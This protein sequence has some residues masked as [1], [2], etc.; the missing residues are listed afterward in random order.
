MDMEKFYKK[1]KI[2]MNGLIMWIVPWLFLFIL[3]PKDPSFYL[4]DVE[5]SLIA[6]K[7]NLVLMGISLVVI[8]LVS[9]LL[10]HLK[11]TKS[12]SYKPLF[13]ISTII[14]TAII[15]ILLYWINFFRGLVDF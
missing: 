6:L 13:W 7:V 15:L 14:Y 10:Q 11:K 1:H 8:F 4:E 2:V 12:D 3:Y 5:Y 9:L